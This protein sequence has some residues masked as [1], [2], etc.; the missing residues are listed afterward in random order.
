[1]QESG[2]QYNALK[3]VNIVG[4]GGN[5][6]AALQRKEIDMAVVWQPFCAQVFNDSRLFRLI[7]DEVERRCPTSIWMAREYAELAPEERCG[8]RLPR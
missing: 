3:I 5:Y 4:G 6:L 2:L 7:V 1:M 8:R